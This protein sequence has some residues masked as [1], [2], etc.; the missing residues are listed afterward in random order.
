MTFLKKLSNTKIEWTCRNKYGV[1][2]LFYFKMQ[3]FKQTLCTV[4]NKKATKKRK[5][6]VHFT[7]YLEALHEKV[8]LFF[9]SSLLTIKTI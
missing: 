6:I 9:S 1:K 7:K 2:S 5:K 8:R 3:K 4:M